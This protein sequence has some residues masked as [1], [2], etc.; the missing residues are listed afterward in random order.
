MKKNWTRRILSGIADGIFPAVSGSITYS[1]DKGRE[2]DYAR[3]TASV[4]SWSLFIAF[5]KGWITL[6]Q[7]VEILRILLTAGE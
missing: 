2:I 7:T 4:L 3:F 6:E 5:V 1:S